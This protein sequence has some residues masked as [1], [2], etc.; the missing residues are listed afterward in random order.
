MVEKSSGSSDAI[1][2]K[3]YANRRLYN[4]STSSY[5]TLGT[6]CMMVKEG[7]DFVVRDAKSG[8][9]ITRSVLTQI[10]F[11]EENKGQNLLPIFFLRQLIC[12]YG[13]SLQNM[14]PRYLD[15]TMAA[16]TQNQEQF[17]Q[18]ISKNMVNANSIL[19]MEEL[20][21]QNL[22]VF[23]QIEGMF[24]PSGGDGQERDGAREP[25]PHTT[26]LPDNDVNDELVR[27]RQQLA[28]MQ[29]QLNRLFE[30]G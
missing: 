2:I 11:E 13:D 21:Q 25:K 22:A 3:K 9:D 7:Q 6:L 17:R 28:Q 19:K 5:V 15:S 24:S 12:F 1:V 29:Q 30:K 4:T 18:H 16:F 10:I 23:Q 14:V 26:T 27:L 20:G 8:E